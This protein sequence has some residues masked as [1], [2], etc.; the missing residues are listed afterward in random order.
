MLARTLGV[1]AVGLGPSSFWN[2]ATNALKA[3]LST[4]PGSRFGKDMN[5]TS[6]PA[7]EKSR[8]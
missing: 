8:V 1:P 6:V 2:P 5:G 4:R 3:S 7:C